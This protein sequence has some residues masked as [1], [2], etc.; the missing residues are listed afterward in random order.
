MREP[1]RDVEYEDRDVIV[2]DGGSSVASLL[3]IV[4][5]IVVVLAIVW[6]FFLSGNQ[7]SPSDIN[8][9]VQPT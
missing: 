1:E 6:F 2:T 3:G 5:A 4:L 8:I 9:Q 7:A